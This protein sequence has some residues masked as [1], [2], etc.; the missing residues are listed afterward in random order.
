MSLC[1]SAQTLLVGAEADKKLPLGFSV[2]AGAEYRT[3]HW[4]DDSEQWSVN[5]EV[6]YK[7][8]AAKWFKATI[9]YKFIQQKTPGVTIDRFNNFNIHSYWTDRH[10]LSISVSGEWKPIS[11]LSLSL[12][13]R[14]QFTR[15]PEKTVALFDE[16]WEPD[17]DKTVS[18]KDQHIMRTRLQAEYKP[19]KKCP[20]TPYASWELY[21]LLQEKN[22]TKNKTQGGKFNDRWRLT[23]G[24]EWKISKKAGSLDLF[25][26]Y[27]KNADDLENDEPHTIGLVYNFKF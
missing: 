8:Q 4:F 9:G 15:R 27:T 25:Y 23:A 12:R 16:D 7:P 24:C 6:G 1:A 5:A 20:F 19:Y 13:E 3:T 10:R 17:G 26:R 11:Q 22:L 2:G 18:A 21:S 14:Y